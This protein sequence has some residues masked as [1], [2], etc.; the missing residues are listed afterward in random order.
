MNY[1]FTCLIFKTICMGSFFLFI[2]VWIFISLTIRKLITL[3]ESRWELRNGIV[4]TKVL[5]VTILWAALT[6]AVWLKYLWLEERRV[7]LADIVLG[8]L[9]LN[10]FRY[11]KSSRCCLMGS[12]RAQ[13]III[14]KHTLWMDACN[15]AKWS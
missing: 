2:H 1:K 15:I 13:L 8:N 7:T 11:Y 4:Q 12:L 6:R 5:T 14:T 10:S 3:E 9:I